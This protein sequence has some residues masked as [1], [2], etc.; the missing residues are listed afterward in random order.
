MPNPLL[1]PVQIPTFSDIIPNQHIESALTEILA[2]YRKKLVELVKQEEFTWDNFSVHIEAQ[3]ERLDNMWVVVDHMCQVLGTD[4]LREIHKKG[5]A[6]IA[7]FKAELMQNADYYRAVRSIANSAAFNALSKP[8][9]KTINL[10]LLDFRLGGVDL[11]ADKKQR[12]VELNQAIK[13][14]E[15]EFA[16]NTLKATEGWT[17]HVTDINDLKGF[18]QSDLDNAA[19]LA[20]KQ[21]KD[22]W[23]LTLKFPVYMAAMKLIE[24]RNIRKQM[25]SAYFTRASDQGPD[26]GKWD[27]GPVIENI[28]KMRHEKAQL[29]GYQNFAELSVAKKMAKD[30][31]RV[32][33][34]LNE[35]ASKSVIAAKNELAEI[36]KFAA[37]KDGIV[38]FQPW[39][40]TFYAEKLRQ[41]K[42]N[43]SQEE[44]KPYFP[45]E[46]VLS[47]YFSILNTLYGITLRKVKPV[48]TWHTDVTYYEVYDESGDFR[49]SVYMDLY[50][51]AGKREGAWMTPV[52]ARMKMPDGSMRFP[53]AFLSTNFAKPEDDKP[54]LLTEANVK[55]LFHEFGHCLH[56]VLT[57]M[58][59]R[60]VSGLNGVPWDGVEFPSQI[61]EHFICNK[62]TIKLISGHYQ[63]NEPMP[64]SLYKNML[65]AKNFQSAMMTVRQLEYAL[66]DFRVHLEYDPA[67]GARTI[68]ILTSVQDSVAVMKTPLDA[69][70]VPHTFTHIFAN[71]YSAGYY[72]YKWAE[73]LTCDAFS[74]FD[75]AGTLSSEVGREYMHIILEQGGTPDF[76]EAFIQ[77]RGRPPKIDA[78]LRYAGLD[79]LPAISEEGKMLAPNLFNKPQDMKESKETEALKVNDKSQL[80]SAS[81]MG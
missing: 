11:P 38:D 23:V 3:E 17:L 24:D 18:P 78:L 34:F 27:N 66:F 19:T 80:L 57:K 56:D 55:S 2:D 81:K 46:K 39:D 40:T 21:G 37:E 75:E 69:N 44:L 43:V 48:D 71:D 8:Q 7:E 49:G 73:V 70:R 61:M 14:E 30:P 6:T 65:A 53:I 33:A 59:V 36:K 32:M 68:P 52:R 72:G 74:R 25:Y 41:H 77:F 63:T 51:R 42:Y 60:T 16:A 15:T 22:G 58:E 45:F 67:H 50:A 64:E 76:L 29:L 47:G 13:K 12:V 31:Q 5:E 79:K 1:N 62:K 20:A 26:A 4:E 35:L 54:S 9:Q 10:L 28:L